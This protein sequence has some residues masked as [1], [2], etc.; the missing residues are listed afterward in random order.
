MQLSGEIDELGG[1]G[2]KKMVE[3]RVV[4]PLTS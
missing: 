2:Y 4:E 1:V 3:L